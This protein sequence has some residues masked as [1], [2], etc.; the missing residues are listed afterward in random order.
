MR[1]VRVDSLVG[2]VSHFELSAESAALQLACCGL[3]GLDKTL[4]M[5]W[6]GEQKKLPGRATTR[7]L[8]VIFSTQS[9]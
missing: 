2:I 3:L 4:R 9:Y 7:E 5:L 1:G 8:W 6:Q